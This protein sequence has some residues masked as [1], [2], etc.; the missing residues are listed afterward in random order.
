MP[1]ICL[2][3]SLVLLFQ[4]ILSAEPSS[5][6]EE[7]AGKFVAQVAAGEFDKAVEPFDKTMKQALPAE[8]L[9]QLWEG[10]TKEYGPWQRAAGTRTEKIQKYTAVY[11]TCEFQKSKLDTKVVFSSDKKITGL[12]FVP[13]GKYE[14]PSYANFSKFEEKESKS[15]KGCGAFPEHLLC[16]KATAP[17]R[18]SSWFMA[19]DRKIETKPSAPTSLFA[20][21]HMV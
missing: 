5:E 17:F 15:A 19:Q 14:P 11:V 10:L 8:K 1:A 12:F 13:A 21:W 3:L 18:R 9:R 2:I 7:L 20:I 4:G 16:P 6:Q